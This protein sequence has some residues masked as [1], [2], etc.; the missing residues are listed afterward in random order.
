[1]SSKALSVMAEAP[2]YHGAPTKTCCKE[3]R[4]GFG[5]VAL[6]HVRRFSYRAMTCWIVFVPSPNAL[7][8]IYL[9][10]AF[11]QCSSSRPH[12]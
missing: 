5:L 2:I 9:T 7:P 12:S 3:F 10:I 1:M 6:T 4:V 11:R 8:L